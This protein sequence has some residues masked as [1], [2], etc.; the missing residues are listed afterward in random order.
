LIFIEKTK[1][2]RAVIMT[3]DYDGLL[4]FSSWFNG[5]GN[6]ITICFLKKRIN[7]SNSHTAMMQPKNVRTAAKI[8]QAPLVIKQINAPK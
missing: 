1:N 8:V 4:N 6:I 3:T 2:M 5:S 7:K